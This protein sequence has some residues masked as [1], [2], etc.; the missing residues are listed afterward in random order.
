MLLP[1]Q[2]SRSEETALVIGRPG[3]ILRPVIGGI[4]PFRVPQS[5]TLLR[6]VVILSLVC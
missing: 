1:G 4:F 6:W 5:A 3:W 2:N